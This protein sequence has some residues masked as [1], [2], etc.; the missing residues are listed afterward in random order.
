MMKFLKYTVCESKIEP[1]YIRAQFYFCKLYIKLE[2]ICKK[3]VFENVAQE[4]DKFSSIFV[5][6]KIYLFD[7]FIKDWP[8]KKFLKNFLYYYFL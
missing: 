7:H 3:N 1:F 4:I 6:L 8:Y 5:C 2:I